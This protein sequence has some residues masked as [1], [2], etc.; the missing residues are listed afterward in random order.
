M[1]SD[2]I[3]ASCALSGSAGV[4]SRRHNRMTPSSSPDATNSGEMATARA[5]LSCP[6]WDPFEFAVQI[7]PHT[8]VEPNGRNISTVGENVTS[9][10]LAG[11][12]RRA[13]VSRPEDVPNAD[14][15]AGLHH[16]EAIRVDRRKPRALAYWTDFAATASAPPEGAD[17][18]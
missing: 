18:H 11:S 9:I 17:R 2:R 4:P 14:H 6:P 16:H 10:A 12:L 15:S 13:A 7:P 3:A 8:A 5:G 1:A